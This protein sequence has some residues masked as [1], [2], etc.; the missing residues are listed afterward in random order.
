[1]NQF[2]ALHVAIL[3]RCSRHEKTLYPYVPQ[4]HGFP[5]HMGSPT[6]VARG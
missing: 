1:M 3:Q 5:N 2:A 4:S 6:K